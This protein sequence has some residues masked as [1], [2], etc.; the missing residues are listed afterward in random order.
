MKRF[1]SLPRKLV[2]WP[3]WS[4]RIHAAARGFL[5][6]PKKLVK[7]PFAADIQES[8]SGTG[9]DGVGAFIAL[10]TFALA[11]GGALTAVAKRERRDNIVLTIY[12]IIVLVTAAWII[13]M[14]RSTTDEAVG[15]PPKPVTVRAFDR[16]SIRYGRFTLG[17]TVV[18]GL[19]MVFLAVNQLL[20]N[21]TNR[22]AYLKDKIDSDPF[23]LTGK[24]NDALASLGGDV[25][26]RNASETWIRWI[27]DAE[28]RAQVQAKAKNQPIDK[29]IIWIEQRSPFQEYYK[30]FAARLKY[31]NQRFKITDR[32]A[33]L[34]KRDPG[35]GRPVYRQVLF[36][37]ENDGFSD[38]FDL[39]E[40]DPDEV[41]I[42]MAY[43]EAVDGGRLTDDTKQYKLDIELSK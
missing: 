6:L 14:L 21:Q 5:S 16:T 41:L 20:P 15:T 43:I 40:P 28:L 1:P 42:I 39:M 11:E 3:A 35:L 36:R 30:S 29:R 13:A 23:L 32:V 33:F 12:G 27:A 17:W 2:K 25:Q 19:I 34:I 18:L 37:R 38:T 31:D 10:A 9:K 7:W 4:G 26:D 24:R 22:V 8:P